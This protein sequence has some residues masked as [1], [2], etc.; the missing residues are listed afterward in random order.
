MK[1]LITGAGGQVGL[2]LQ[3]AKWPEGT[4][5]LAYSHHEFDIADEGAI[6]RKITPSTGLVINPAAYTAVDRAENDREAASRINAL[7]PGL[8][9]LRCAALNIPLVHVSTDYVFDGAKGS[10]YVE[11][12]PTEPLNYYGATKLEGEQAVR[13][14]TK[15]HVIM[16]TAS[17]FSAHG[18][19]FVKTMIR[20]A[21]ERSCLKIVSDQTSSPTAASDIAEA[22]VRIAH[23]IKSRS[24]DELWGT[25]HFCGGP[26]VTWFNFAQAIFDAAGRRGVAAPE[27]QPMP[28]DQYPTAATRPRFSVMDCTKIQRTMDIETPLWAARLPSVVDAIVGG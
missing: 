15:R 4:E 25:Y 9:A 28:A 8:I 22:I 12:D 21:R 10:P 11:N 18:T 26:G 23:Q 6:E 5:L 16:R 3:Q 7:A 2:E 27:L 20:L 14:A 1:V 17:V 24:G 13:A 19:N